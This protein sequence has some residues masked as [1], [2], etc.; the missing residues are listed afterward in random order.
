MLIE[1]FNQLA[2]TTTNFSDITGELT[3][4]VST[5]CVWKVLGELTKDDGHVDHLDFYWAC[6]INWLSKQ[7]SGIVP[8]NRHSQ[9][10]LNAELAKVERAEQEKAEKAFAQAYPKIGQSTWGMTEKQEK[11]TLLEKFKK[12][13]QRS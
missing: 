1:M 11:L 3:G 2:V 4:E 5:K 9:R 8:L 12:V 13:I 6:L 7:V 10:I